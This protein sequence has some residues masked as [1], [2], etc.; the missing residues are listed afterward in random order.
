V[1]EDR[2]GVWAKTREF[3]VKDGPTAVLIDGEQ[4]LSLRSPVCL[5]AHRFTQRIHRRT[6][7]NA[8]RVPNE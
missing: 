1:E 6:P 8:Q 4:S 3:T 2:T 5:V 7:L